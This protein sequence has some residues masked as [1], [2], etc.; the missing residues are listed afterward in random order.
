M[1]AA[2][3]TG[4]AASRGRYVAFLDADD[5]LLPDALRF[6]LE[7]FRHHP[8]C[9]FVSGHYRKID[10]EGRPIPIAPRPC[11]TSDHYRT[12][13]RENYIGM[14]ATVLFRRDALETVGG[15]DGGGFGMSS[16]GRWPAMGE[17]RACARSATDSDAVR[18]RS[19]ILGGASLGF[20][21]RP[22]AGA[23]RLGAS[24]IV[25]DRAGSG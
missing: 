9:A 20:A 18:S 21:V 3:N 2:R 1:A 24:T 22:R 8:E 13:L 6:G 16:S 17:F 7:C 25:I 15:F 10:I 12:L 4:I 14:H 23:R 19:I 11:V 5:R